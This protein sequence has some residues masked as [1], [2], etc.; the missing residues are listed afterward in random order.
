M[1]EAAHESVMKQIAL[2]PFVDLTKLSAEDLTS[3]SNFL[4]HEVTSLQHGIMYQ[5]G[6]YKDT[7]NQLTEVNRVRLERVQIAP[8][9]VDDEP[10][11]EAPKANDEEDADGD[12]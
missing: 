4:R 3:I 1:H 2:F 8:M 9:V 10:K 6:V 12:D 7:Y 5:V 11:E